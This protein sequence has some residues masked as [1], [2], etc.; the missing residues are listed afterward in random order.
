MFN[1]EPE[2][3]CSNQSLNNSL[4]SGD[5]GT[6]SIDVKLKKKSHQRR[7]VSILRYYDSYSKACSLIK[8][9]IRNLN[10]FQSLHSSCENVPIDLN[11]LHES[12]VDSD[13]DLTDSMDVSLSKE[14]FRLISNWIK[15]LVFKRLFSFQ[16]LA[17]RDIVRESLEKDPVDRTDEDIDVLLGFTQSLEAFNKYTIAVR[18]ALCSGK[19]FFKNAYSSIMFFDKFILTFLVMVFAV[20]DKAGTIVMND[21]VKVAHY[22]YQS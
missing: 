9:L 3:K 8:R 22:A 15:F 10:L 11:G 18:R 19:L 20:V 12:V 7:A 17:I 13:E 16:S 4:V 1:M 21:R 14:I 2:V 5:S 6:F